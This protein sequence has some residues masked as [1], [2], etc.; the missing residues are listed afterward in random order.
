[1]QTVI[2]ALGILDLMV[3]GV[4]GIDELYWH[5]VCFSRRQRLTA[6]TILAKQTEYCILILFS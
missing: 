3:A 6:Y 1:M 4:A 2:I 5:T